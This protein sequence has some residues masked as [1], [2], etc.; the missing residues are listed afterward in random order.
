MLTARLFTHRTSPTLGRRYVYLYSVDF[1][2]DII[3]DHSPDPEADAA[4]ALLAR[5][6]TGKLTM[7]D[8]ETGKPCTIVNI[9]KAAKL[10]TREGPLRFAPYEESRPNSRYSPETPFPIGDPREAA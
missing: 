10:C 6:I 3:V 2:G 7:I 5:G 8:A 9:E 1:D 4:R